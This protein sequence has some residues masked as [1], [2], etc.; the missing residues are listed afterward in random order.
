MLRRCRSLTSTTE[1]KTFAGVC[2][3]FPKCVALGIEV[4]GGLECGRIARNLRAPGCELEL[5]VKWCSN[6]NSYWAG[7]RDF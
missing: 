1:G 7:S 3:Q 2:P 4:D 5:G 6:R